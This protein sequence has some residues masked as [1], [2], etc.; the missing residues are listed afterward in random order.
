MSCNDFCSK[1][2]NVGKFTK[3]IIIRLKEQ[4]LQR[5]LMFYG[6]NKLLTTVN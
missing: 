6:P 3:K 4:N 5:E 2:S 1:S